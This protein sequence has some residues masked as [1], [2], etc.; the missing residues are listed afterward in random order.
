MKLRF[1]DITFV[2]V[3][4]SFSIILGCSIDGSSDVNDQVDQLINN[5]QQEAAALEA[6]AAANDSSSDSSSSD[7]SSSASTSSDSSSSSSASSSSSSSSGSVGGFVWKPISE[8]DGNLVV[9]L[10]SA[11]ANR[12]TDVSIRKGGSVVERG[13]FTGNT[14]GNRPTYR[15][16]QPGSGYGSGLTVVATLSDGS[17]KTWSI[18]NGGTRV[19]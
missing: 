2:I 10:P 18:P 11:Y 17:T 13:R 7:S 12:V 4:S 8:G 5:S 14:N 16:R 1:R 15:Y 9:L 6:A 19:G 3:L